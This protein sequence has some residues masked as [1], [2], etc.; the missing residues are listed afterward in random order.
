MIREGAEGKRGE[1]TQTL[2]AHVNIRKKKSTC[3]ANVK[4]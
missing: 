3:L 4:P 2:Y 1:M